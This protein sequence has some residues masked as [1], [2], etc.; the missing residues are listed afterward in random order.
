VTQR[1]P[2]LK[3]KSCA[4]GTS[5]VRETDSGRR[6]TRASTVQRWRAR[7]RRAVTRVALTPVQINAA[8]LKM[9]RDFS[10]ARLSQTV[11]RMHSGAPVV[12]APPNVSAQSCSGDAACISH[13]GATTACRETTCWIPMHLVFAARASACTAS[14][15]VAQSTNTAAASC[16]SLFQHVVCARRNMSRPEPKLKNS[17]KT[18]PSLAAV[19]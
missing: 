9:T 2:K 1:S 19:S 17:L 8:R 3:S 15:V 4:L 14:R 7:L 18:Q 5:V 12:K 6:R 10:Y 13:R 11:L 16:Y